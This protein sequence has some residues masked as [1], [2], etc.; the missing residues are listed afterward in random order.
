L[1][2]R[3]LAFQSFFCAGYFAGAEVFSKTADWAYLFQCFFAAGAFF[4]VYL[5]AGMAFE[6]HNPVYKPAI[7]KPFLCKIT[8]TK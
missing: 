5:S 3:N 4:E 2:N 1:K 8:T 7:F 6:V